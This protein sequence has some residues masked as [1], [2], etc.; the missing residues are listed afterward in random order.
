VIAR[1]LLLALGLALAI[2]AGLIAAEGVSPLTA[3]AALLN[4]AFG[5]SWQWAQD[6]AKATP[7]LL[8]AVGVALCFRGGLINI[9]GEG[10]IA[11][12]GLAS[13]WATLRL[14]GA[15]P[16]VAIPVGLLA[17]MAGGMAWAGL[18]AL[19]HLWRG[20]HEVL[21]TLLMNFIA[22]LMVGRALEGPLADT[23]AGFPQSPLLPRAA[24]LPRVVAHTDL[25]IGL[26]LALAV[27]VLAHVALWH[28]VW[29]FA[30]R[31]AGASR[32]AARYAGFSWPGTVLGMMLAAGATAGLAGAVQVMGIHHRLI[33]GF[34][35]G[36]GFVSVAIALL[37]GLSPLA[38]IPAALLFGALET[39]ALSMQRQIGVPSSLVAVIE[40]MMMLF[41]LAAMAARARAA[42]A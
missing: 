39:G 10:Q 1:R 21:V 40:G 12:G 24:W 28:T 34:S 16:A 5:A 26:A 25:T 19:L 27:A 9:G 33:E 22:L 29:G 8:C 35:G 4:G 30:I 14:P 7:Y 42:R 18:A 41:V 3:Y 13:A 11:I 2:A 17:G 6:G 23:G 37:G 20:V 31:T 32:R 15:G 38:V 36:F